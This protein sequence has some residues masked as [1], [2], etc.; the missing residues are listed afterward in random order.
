MKKI[1]ISII[2]ATRNRE[3]IL[4]TTIEKAISAID[5][6]DTEIIIINDGDRSLEVP[7]AFQCKINYFD[8]YKSGVSSAR[9]YGASKATGSLFFFIDDD[10][11]IS[12]EAILWITRFMSDEK[13]T[14]AVYN[15]NWEYPPC[16]TERLVKT[17]VGKYLLSSHYNTMWGRMDQQGSRP[18]SGLHKYFH[19]GSCSLLMHK[20][21][22]NTLEGY[23]ESIIFQGE[24]VDLANRIYKL[25]I[26]LFCVFDI[27][28]HHNHADRLDLDGHLQR[29]GRGYESQFMAEKTGIISPGNYYKPPIIVIFEICRITEKLWIFL[30]RLLP[31]HRI[32]KMFT[33]K[34]TGYLSALQRYKQWSNIMLKN[35][36]G[37]L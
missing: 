3:S 28:L 13:N 29:V 25:S 18:L 27:T 1:N 14:G 10:M 6:T 11:W 35:N 19:L 26:P 5:G 16:L 31:N 24:D 21:V 37:R 36:R 34:L 30:H 2:I 9:N 17:K 15:L 12:R 8:N 20:N 23:N 4:W 33:N 32:F 22:F 7:L